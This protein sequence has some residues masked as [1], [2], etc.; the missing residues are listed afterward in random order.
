MAQIP[1]G[2]EG[3]VN[4]TVK[5]DNAGGQY[6]RE[7]VRVET[8]D[9]QRQWI[10]LLVRGQ[11]EAFALIGPERVSLIGR[12]GQDLRA[13]VRIQP[14]ADN[15]FKITGV[16]NKQGDKF[17]RYHLVEAPGEDGYRLEVEN[18]SDKK[19]T[20]YDQIVLET[21]SHLRPELKILV[22]GRLS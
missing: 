10:S 20:Y 5:T 3:K 8:N 15:P 21:D 14:R 17:I 11:V 13:T 1:P 18:R 7:G 22:M 4:V 9:P 19:G 12:I 2:G 6:I 16:H